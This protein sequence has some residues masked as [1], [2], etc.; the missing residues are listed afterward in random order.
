MFDSFANGK[1]PFLVDLSRADMLNT[2]LDYI[3]PASENIE[4][5][6]RAF[7]YGADTNWGYVPIADQKIAVLKYEKELFVI[8]VTDATAVIGSEDS[9]SPILIKD[10]AS[11]TESNKSLVDAYTSIDNAAQFY[12]RA[13][14]YLVD[15]YDGETEALVSKDRNLVDA[16]DYNVTIDANATN[17]FA[18]DGTTITIKADTFVGEIKTTGTFTLNN[19]AEIYGGYIDMTGTNKF[20]HLDWGDTIGQLISVINLDNDNAIIDDLL[21]TLNYQ[22]HFLMPDP[23]PAAGIQVQIS[24]PSGFKMFEEL[25]PA[26]D[27]N[28]IR[29]DITLTASE[30]RQIEMLFLARKL[31]QKSEGINEALTGTTP[32]I[33]DNTTVTNSNS[34]AT[35]ENQ[36]AILDLLR[37]ILNKVSANREAFKGN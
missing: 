17:A 32:S 8:D 16:G 4:I 7:R 12:D 9:Y 30:E 33:T 19:D 25:I 36:V 13:K 14:A 20:I 23:A 15:N 2:T 6:T 31:L 22:G 28:F 27:L 10:D 26:D 11:I 1:A 24:T 21:D 3:L 34:T 5:V 35:N 37:R 29:T 18:F